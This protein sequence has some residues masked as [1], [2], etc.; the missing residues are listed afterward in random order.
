MAQPFAFGCNNVSGQCNI[1][2]SGGE[3]S[4][5]Q[6]AAGLVHSVLLKSDGSA[7]A[8]GTNANGQRTFLPQVVRQATPKPLQDWFTSLAKERWLSSSFWN[9][10]QRTENIPASDGETSYTQSAARNCHTV[11]MRSDCSVVDFGCNNDGQCM[12]PECSWWQHLFGKA[13]IYV[14]PKSLA[15]MKCVSEAL[16]LLA[17][18]F[19]SYALR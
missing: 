5:T 10:C 4:Y 14:P 9:Q 17:G 18:T 12:I 2:A 6:A 16:Q 11:L 8:F 19:A 1:P 3:T 7:V 13:W 15:M